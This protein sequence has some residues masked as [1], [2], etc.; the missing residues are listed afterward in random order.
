M[1]GAPKLAD[2][3][4][5]TEA[6]GVQSQTG[7]QGFIP[8]EGSGTIRADIY[9]LGKVLY[10]ISTGLDRNE[11]PVCGNILWKAVRQGRWSAAWRKKALGTLKDGR[12]PTT[13]SL[14]L[15]EEG[16]ASPPPL[17]VRFVTASMWRWRSA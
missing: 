14:E 5:V 6:A 11:Y 10:E 15:L 16:S 13:S 17:I 4:L 9:S 1:N 12:F 8:P 3:G 2:I 7:T